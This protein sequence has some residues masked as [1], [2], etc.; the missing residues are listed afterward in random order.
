MVATFPKQNKFDII[1]QKVELAKVT[2]PEF[3]EK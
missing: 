3:E 1:N 2:D